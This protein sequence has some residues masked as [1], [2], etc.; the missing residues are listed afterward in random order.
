MD[1][2]IAK[3]SNIAAQRK[4]LQSEYQANLA[5]LAEQEQA[6]LQ[7]L[8]AE[9]S[10]PTP[11][12][13][14]AKKRTVQWNDGCQKLSPQ[15]FKLLDALYFAENQELTLNDLEAAVWGDEA[16]VNLG[17]IKTAMCRLGND[18]VNANSPFLIE[19]VL[20]KGGETMEVSDANG[21]R[22]VKTRPALIGYR[23]VLRVTDSEQAL[24]SSS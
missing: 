16:D 20:S 11:P 10:R 6:L 21:V 8:K 1:E 19:S 7:Q 3:L 13:F 23:L 4:K 22:T 17:T 15:R 14:E 18:L 12:T 24:P 2:T 9:K 5:A